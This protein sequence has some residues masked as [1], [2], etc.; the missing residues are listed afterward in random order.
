MDLKFLKLGDVVTTDTVWKK[1]NNKSY[2]S[3]AVCSVISYVNLVFPPDLIILKYFQ[4][5]S[6]LTCVVGL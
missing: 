3:K 5:Q 4:F 2:K 1:E 6:V